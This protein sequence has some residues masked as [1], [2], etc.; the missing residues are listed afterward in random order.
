MIVLHSYRSIYLVYILR[1]HAQGEEMFQ[2]KIHQPKI[3]I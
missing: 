3:L 1:I 2:G